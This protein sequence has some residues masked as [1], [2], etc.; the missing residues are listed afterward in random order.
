MNWATASSASWSIISTAAGTMPAA[1]M[2][3]TAALQAATE[4][5]E[6]SSVRTPAGV[7]TSWTTA[8]VTMPKVPSL[9]QNSPVRS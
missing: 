5:N 2:P 9:P 8:L 4:S 6:A 3:E 7:C 1:T